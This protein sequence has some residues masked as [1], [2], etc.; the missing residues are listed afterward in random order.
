[1]S[2][3]Q[4]HEADP[5]VKELLAQVGE[6]YCGIVSELEIAILSEDQVSEEDGA[7]L[8]TTEEVLARM[9]SKSEICRVPNVGQKCQKY[10]FY[11][12]LTNFPFWS[13]LKS[14]QKTTYVC[15]RI[16]REFVLI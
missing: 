3:D 16:S 8:R 4:Y 1:M 15:N 5:L 11:F 9:L 13:N 6:E 14:P 7:L 10:T 12:T 2:Q